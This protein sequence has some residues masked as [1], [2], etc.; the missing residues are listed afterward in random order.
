MC[1]IFPELRGVKLSHAW[2]G[3]VAFTFD[4][5]PHMGADGAAGSGLRWCL[6]CNGSGVVMMTHLGHRT[7]LKILGRTNRASAFEELPTPTA[8][9]Y[10]G[11]P[12]FLPV[13]GEYYKIRDW[14]DRRVAES[15]RAG[16]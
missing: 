15:T 16:A 6:G 14:I 12:W 9:F 3:N 10:T 13:I 2:N 11:K 7:A 1:G 5:V 4:R 8:P